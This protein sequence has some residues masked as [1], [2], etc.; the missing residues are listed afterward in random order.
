MRCSFCAFSKS[1]STTPDPVDINTLLSKLEI[2]LQTDEFEA[3]GFTGGEPTLVPEYLVRAIQL[4][5]QYNP[6]S[7]ININTNGTGLTPNLVS[8]LNYYNVA[9]RFAFSGISEGEKSLEYAIKISE[10]PN[11]L[12]LIQQVKFKCLLMIAFKSKP[13]AEEVVK[14]F[15]KIK[16]TSLQINPDQMD[17][18][19]SLTDLLFI[20]KELVKLNEMMPNIHK[21]TSFFGSTRHCPASLCYNFTITG[22]L[23]PFN[24]IKSDAWDGCPDLIKGFGNSIDNI[25]YYADLAERNRKG[26]V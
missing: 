10:Q 23:E 7:I 2:V 3:F 21:D 16:F 20:E 4:I 17:Y 26:F 25:K 22:E 13:F 1:L 8:F 14:L 9:L 19:F 24:C 11:L 5:R 18:S 15:S 12:S 6:D